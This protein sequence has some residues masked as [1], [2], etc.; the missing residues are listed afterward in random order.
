M[1]EKTQKEEPKEEPQEP[2]LF[3]QSYIEQQRSPPW[4]L[5]GFLLFAILGAFWK[6]LIMPKIAKEEAAIVKQENG[7]TSQKIKSKN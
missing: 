3:D 2:I 7:Q 4:I 5:I 1:D 6:K